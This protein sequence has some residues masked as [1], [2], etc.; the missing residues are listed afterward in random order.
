MENLDYSL[1]LRVALFDAYSHVKTN[2]I[3]ENP[4]DR[5]GRKDN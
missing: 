1:T 3:I 4:H 2:S 5:L